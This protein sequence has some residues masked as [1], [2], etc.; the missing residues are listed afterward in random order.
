MAYVC[1]IGF[2]TEAMRRNVRDTYE[3]LADHPEGNYHFH[4]GAAYAAGLLK[5][6]Q[7]DL[8]ALPKDSVARFAGVGNPLRVGPIHR[9]EVV[10][11]HACGAG[12][13]LLLAARRVGPTGRAIGVDMT[14]GMRSYARTGAQKAGFAAR[15]DIREGYF[16]ALPL[17][18]GCVDVV[19]SN[20]VV[21]LAPDK[22]L[23]F[24]EIA[25]V[26]K[27][28]GRLYL[29]DVT[30]S[31]ELGLDARANPEL[32]AGC[33]AGALTEEELLSLCWHAGLL[34]SRVTERFD[35]F[36]DTSARRKVNA[37]FEIWGSN[38]L[39]FKG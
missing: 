24:R 3:K 14:P 19:L 36:R 5:Y 31:G 16:E 12:V 17:E 13:D 7:A 15:V 34:H 1:P 29:A 26:L 33:V 8:D 4:R 10:L 28:G 18:D 32:W 25:R 21:N 9:G 11:G 20:G 37:K 35:C 6:S 27:P 39:A 23:V 22:T 38:I 30:L 2:D